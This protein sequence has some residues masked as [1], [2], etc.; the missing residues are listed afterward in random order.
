MRIAAPIISCTKATTSEAGIHG[1]PSRAV[2][3]DGRRSAGWTSCSARTL[4]SKAG[5]SAAAAAGG[6]TVAAGCA[7]A[8]A[9]A[10]SRSRARAFLIAVP[11]ASV[12]R[13]GS[14]GK[15]CRPSL[16]SRGWRVSGRSLRCGVLGQSS[17]ARRPTSSARVRLGRSKR[18]SRRRWRNWDRSIIDGSRPMTPR[19]SD[20]PARQQPARPKRCRNARPDRRPPLRR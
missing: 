13:S 1:A 15:R 8:G 11:P 17:H 6:A 7:S 3:S 19:A 16:L 14:G 4:R 9:V 10:S 18:R 12:R 5:S 2:I 20:R